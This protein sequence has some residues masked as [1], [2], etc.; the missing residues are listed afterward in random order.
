MHK[1]TFCWRDKRH[2]ISTVIASADTSHSH[3]YGIQIALNT[4][5][6]SKGEPLN[7]TRRHDSSS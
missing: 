7:S 2:L 4:F 3:A 6:Q 1:S 5:V